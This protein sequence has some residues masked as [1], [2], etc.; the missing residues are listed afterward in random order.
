MLAIILAYAYKEK[1]GV[2]FYYFY[3]LNFLHCILPESSS[4]IAFYINMKLY[5][6]CT[7]WANSKK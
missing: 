1:I 6:R 7:L 3:N 5:S 4:S 2:D